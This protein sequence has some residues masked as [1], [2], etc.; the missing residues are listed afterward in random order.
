MALLSPLESEYSEREMVDVF[1]GYNH[2]LKIVDG[3]FYNTK[4]LSTSLYPLLSNRKKRG[5]VQTMTAPGGLLAKEHLAYVDD[6]TLY[7]NGTATPVTGLSAGEKQLVSMGAYIVIF[8]DKQYYNTDDATDYGSMDALYSSAGL[9]KY[10]MCKMDG[11]EYSNPTKSS[12]AP[13]N[14][15]NGDL[16]IDT[17]QTSHVLK[18]YSSATAQWTS[19]AT[20][21]TK[22]TFD[23]NGVVPSMFNEYDGVSISGAETDVNGEKVIY[24]I[25]GDT[26]TYDYIIVVGLIEQAVDQS[27]GSVRLERKAP[28]MDYVCECQNRLWGCKYGNN[29]NEIYCC[30][31]GDFKNWRQYMGL[32][33]DSWTASVGTDGPWTGC[34]NYLGMPIF[35]KENR[36][37]RVSVSSTGAHQLTDVPC[38]GVQQGSS[39]SLAVVNEVL[40]YKSRADVCAYQGGFPSTISSQFGEEQYSDAVAGTVGDKYYISMKDGTDWHL[41]V[42]DVR[43]GLWMREDNLHVSSFASIGDELYCIAD[44]RLYALNGTEGDL[45]PFVEWEAET[46]MLYYQLPDRKYVSRFNVRLFMEEGAELDIYMMYDSNNEWKRQ[47]RIKK[48]GTNTVTVPIRPRR[49]DHCRIKLVGKGE[50]KIYSIAKILTYGSDVG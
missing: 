39:K 1:A 4:N 30:A 22:I 41:F 9:V 7:Y 49:C 17:S 46:G 36:M 24:G 29:L 23:T 13:A 48:R 40:F 26:T 50:V 8:P 11:T 38:R 42:Y 16:W 18:E 43:R 5:I 14:P 12:T 28:D 27:T 44:K 19:I 20:V 35:F 15:S 37:H 10:R 33:T 45:E 34:I 25:G 21:Y 31:L 6:G 47:G 32:S 3:E 2:N